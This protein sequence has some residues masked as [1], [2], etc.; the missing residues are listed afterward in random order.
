MVFER[1]LQELLEK[2]ISTMNSIVGDVVL[3]KGNGRTS[4][5]RKVIHPGYGIYVIVDGAII[6]PHNQV[7]GQLYVLDEEFDTRKHV[8]HYECFDH[9]TYTGTDPAVM[10]RMMWDLLTQLPYSQEQLATMVQ[11]K[12]GKAK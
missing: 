2:K 8:Y 11:K 6:R 9:T 12:Q 10:A 4:L 1:V 3:E 5:K 7:Y